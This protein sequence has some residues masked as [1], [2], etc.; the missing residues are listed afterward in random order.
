MK[1]TFKFQIK[2]QEGLNSMT[3]TARSHSWCASVA[4]AKLNRLYGTDG[5]TLV[6]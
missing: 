3:V 1:K 6:R 4:K 5:F 2:G